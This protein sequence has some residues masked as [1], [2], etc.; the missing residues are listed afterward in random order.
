[1]D[2]ST[3]PVGTRAVVY[4]VPSCEAGDKVKLGT[5]EG[6]SFVHGDAAL[7]EEPF[8]YRVTFVDECGNEQ[9]FCGAT[10]CP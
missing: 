8:N 4:H 1:V 3:N 5:S 2:W 10:D 9:A 6:M 7:T